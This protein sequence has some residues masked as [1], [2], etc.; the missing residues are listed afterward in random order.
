MAINP[1]Q[2]RNKTFQ[3]VR[4][5]YDQPDV[6]RYLAAIAD[7]LEAFNQSAQAEDEIVVADVVDE[8]A[9]P[10]PPKADAA[11]AQGDVEETQTA[12]FTSGSADDFDRVGN[13]ISIMLRQAQE[14]SIKIRNDAEVEART[15]VDQVR[16]DIEAD[17]LAHEEA[18]GELITRTEVR[19]GE[20][21]DEA[22]EYATL[23]RSNADEYATERKSKADREASEMD[24]AAEA[25]RKLAADKLAAASNEAAATIDEAKKRAEEIV[26][27]A[28][29]DAQA[30]SDQMLGEA[31][32]TMTKLIDAEKSSRDNLEEAR[33]NIQTAL[34]QLRLT[35]IES[36]SSSLSSK[37]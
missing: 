20:V 27:N 29:A 5:G 14:S 3:I 26:A 25:D 1:D 31:R 35:D 15:L 9:M 33:K 37:F 12:S 17:R 28:E 16:L 34:E 4:R 24:A 10:P 6:H 8:A 13:E 11:P 30:R 21:R 18:A 7:E 19:A 22:E 36:S 2:V 23:T 32:A